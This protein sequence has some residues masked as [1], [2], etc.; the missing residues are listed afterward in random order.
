MLLF[1]LVKKELETVNILMERE[2]KIKAGYLRNFTRLDLAPIDGVVRS[3]LVILT[4]KLFDQTSSRAI[5]LAA[6]VQFIYLASK[7]HFAIE[8]DSQ[9][10]NSQLECSVNQ[11]PVLVGDYLYGKFFTTLCQNDIVQYLKPLSQVICYIHEGGIERQKAPA[12]KLN[13][14]STLEKIIY[15]ET[16]TLFETA[17]GLAADLAGAAAQDQNTAA[18]FGREFGLAYGLQVENAPSS[19]VSQHLHKAL[20]HLHKLPRNRFRAELEQLTDKLYQSAPLRLE[21]CR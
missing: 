1:N 13:D 19:S 21:E 4:S 8:E 2:Y 6:V 16:A 18:S 10:G 3:G 9:P 15:K 5:N 11:F 7:I 14:I 12:Q 17:C 20:A